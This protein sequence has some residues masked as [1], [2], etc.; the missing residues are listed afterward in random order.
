MIKYETF[1]LRQPIQFTFSVVAKSRR[2]AK[3]L[4]ILHKNNKYPIVSM[5]KLMYVQAAIQCEKVMHYGRGKDHVY[6]VL[7]E[8]KPVGSVN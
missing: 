8:Y 1:D 2:A 4:A 3:V 7:I 5:R 6:E